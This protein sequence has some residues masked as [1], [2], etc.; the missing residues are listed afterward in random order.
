MKNKKSLGIIIAIILAL[1]AVIA[2]VYNKLT[3]EELPTN[4]IS[5]ALDEYS[6]KLDEE[7]SLTDNTDASNYT[8][9]ESESKET[10]TTTEVTDAKQTSEK[11]TTTKKETTTKWTTT[12]K[13]TTTKWT[14]TKKVTT[15][16]KSTTT[17][18]NSTEK[19]NSGIF[20]KDE[21]AAYIHKYGHLPDNFITKNQARALGWQGGSVQKYAP[22]K[23]IGGDY[24][25]NYEETL[26][27][28]QGRKYYECDIN[29]NGK[30]SRGA[31]RIVFSN[32][33]LI[34]YTN[35]HY[36]TFTRLY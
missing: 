33:G 31:E 34:F 6:N 1:C 17:K 21:V 20:S 16:K 14:T 11:V 18:Q 15:T 12:K 26:P 36:E 4:E 19:S 32:D 30:S 3:G 23:A 5:S 24:Y 9:E 28:K 35:D 29:T 25:S 7:A 27:V 8:E 22:G 2:P 10:K 13:V